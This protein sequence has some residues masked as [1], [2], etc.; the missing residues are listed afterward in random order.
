MTNKNF[1][2]LALP[3]SL[4]A[5]VM[6]LK[7]VSRRVKMELKRHP[8]LTHTTRLEETL[9]EINLLIQQMR[10]LE[11]DYVGSDMLLNIGRKNYQKSQIERYSLNPSPYGIVIP[12]GAIKG[13]DNGITVYKVDQWKNFGTIDDYTYQVE[14]IGSS[15]ENPNEYFITLRE[16]PLKEDNVKVRYITVPLEQFA[17]TFYLHDVYFDD[18]SYD[19]E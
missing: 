5:S 11:S 6:E 15:N 19:Y 17:K 14:A 10:Q 1:D 3:K 8:A 9:K 12:K 16:K 2:G 4:N 18:Y 13:F 7:K